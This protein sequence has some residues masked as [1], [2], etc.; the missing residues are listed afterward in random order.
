MQI[1]EAELREAIR[2]SLQPKSDAGMTVQE[3]A[4]MLNVSYSTAYRGVREKLK[5]G[6][7]RR[8]SKVIHTDAG[9]RRVPV[10]IPVNRGE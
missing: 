6:E 3:I 1:T 2:A 5:A 7:F 4:D 8:G 9:N 10:Y